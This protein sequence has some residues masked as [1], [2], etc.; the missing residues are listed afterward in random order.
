VSYRFALSA[1]PCPDDSDCDCGVLERFGGGEP[2]G[3]PLGR[4][5]D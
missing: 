1:P 4:E 2:L 3:L 5:C